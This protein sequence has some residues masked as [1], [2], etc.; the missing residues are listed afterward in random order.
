MKK[1][2]SSSRQASRQHWLERVDAA[3]R[4]YGYEGAARLALDAVAEGV[5]HPALLNLAGLARF[6]EGRFEEAVQFLMRARALAPKDPHVLNS[7]GMSLTALGRTEAAQQAY[8]ASIRVDSSLAA[9]R[10]NRGALLETINDLNGAR[11]DY[12][13]A[14]ALDPN[15]VEPRASL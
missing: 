6:D 3:L 8:D 11:S 15:Y 10:F 14:A 7:L 13:R 2:S 4:N 5:E 12:E 9:V 1:T